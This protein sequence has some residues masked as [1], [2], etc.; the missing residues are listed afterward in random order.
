MFISTY[1]KAIGLGGA[2][3]LASPALA[4]VQEEEP[5]AVDVARTPLDDLNIDSDEIPEIL[6]VAAQAPYAQD[7]LTSCNAIVSE[8]AA[9][10][11]VLGADYDLVGE[12]DTGLTEGKV[13]QSVV[14][15]F[16][17]FRGLIREASGAAGDAR[18]LRAAVTA[19][20]V[21]RGFLKGIGLERGCDYPARPRLQLASE[22]ER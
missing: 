3:A 11:Q 15:S 4:Q 10:D 19:G 14:G 20:M 16:I 9:L 8:I 6:V 5:D 21:R 2:L 13:A 22:D 17:P 1:A 12:S 7:G 18:K